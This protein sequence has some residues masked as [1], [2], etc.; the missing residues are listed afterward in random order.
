[1]VR[2]AKGAVS[3][4]KTLE[5]FRASRTKI[6]ESLFGPNALCAAG[7]IIMPA[8]VFNPD[9]LFRTFQFLFFW[10]LAWLSGKKNNPLFTILVILGIVAFN[11]IVPY[12]QVLFSI[13]AFKITRGAL[14]AGLHRAVTLEALI[15]LSRLTIRSDLKLPGRFG[16]LIGE[17]FRIFA[18]IMNQKHRVTRK[19]LIA[20]IDSLLFELSG[21]SSQALLPDSALQSR[22]KSAGYFILAIVTILSWF[23]ILKTIYAWF[24]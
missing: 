13:G 10:F 18:V 14:V 7:I 15:M 16:G 23:P 24:F 8:L 22:T 12:G 4:M 11:L 6:C 1:M 17:S 3:R 21:D 9:T 20:D 5:Q 19:N 2:S